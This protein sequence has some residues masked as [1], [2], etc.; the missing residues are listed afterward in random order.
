MIGRYLPKTSISIGCE[1]F[2]ADLSNAIGRPSDP[3][4]ALN[5][6]KLFRSSGI[7]P[8]IY[9]IHSLPGE[10]V[11]SLELTKKIVE[12]KIENFAEKITVYKYLPLPGSPFTETNVELPRK[13]H[14]LDTRREELKESIINFNLEKKKKMIGED[15][16]VIIAERDRVRENTYIG[17]PIFSGPAI[18]VY[19]ESEIVGK[20]FTVKVTKAISDKLLK[21]T[22]K[23]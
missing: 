9:L 4:N 15:I 8:Q 6:A 12:T 10:T 18:S 2:D 22:I 17:Y 20:T 5:A 21:G 3:N 14:L 7:D 1:T 23:N 16:V 19:S 13:R 11:K